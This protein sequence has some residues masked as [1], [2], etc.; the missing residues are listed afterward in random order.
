MST[1]LLAAVVVVVVVEHTIQESMTLKN[2]KIHDKQQEK[3]GHC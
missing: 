2:S 3:K 1:L